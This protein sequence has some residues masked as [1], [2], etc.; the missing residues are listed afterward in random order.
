V[1]YPEFRVIEEAL[2][3]DPAEVTVP[4]LPGK[5]AASP[6]GDPLSALVGAVLPNLADGVNEKVADARAREERFAANLGSAR[7]AYHGTDGVGRDQIEA[8]ASKIDPADTFGAGVLADGSAPTPT[9]DAGFS[10][11]TQLMGMAMQAGQQAA[12]MPMQA[13]GMVVQTA[14]P[15]MQGIQGIV[16]QATQASGKSGEGVQPDMAGQGADGGSAGPEMTRQTEKPEGT[17]N[18][19]HSW[20]EDASEPDKDK[21]TSEVTAGAN[22]ANGPRA[23]IAPPQ[24]GTLDPGHGVQHRRITEAAPEVAL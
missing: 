21:E 24:I 12:Q 15:V 1:G 14:E 23:P 6:H 17:D 4:T 3:W 19:D 18:E 8:A 7:T 11:L 2:G 10:Q 5:A 16:Q 9:G 20:S 13:V 22:K